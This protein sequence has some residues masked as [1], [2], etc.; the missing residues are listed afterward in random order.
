M[1]LLLFL[2]LASCSSCRHS[3]S[4]IQELPPT[5]QK[6]KIAL[7]QKKLHLAEKEEKKIH[8][9]VERLSDEMHEARL[10]LIRKQI[11]EYE[12]M[13]RKNPRKKKDLDSGE[14][15]LE[16]R[17]QL[18]RMIQSGASSFEAQLVLD[19]ILQLITNL[20]DERSE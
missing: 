5:K 6:Q 16:E 19:R 13:I 3:S 9:Q 15:F 20:S 10:R 1:L 2:V 18:H 4:A 12:E 17:E 7:L 8:M 11:D 14:L